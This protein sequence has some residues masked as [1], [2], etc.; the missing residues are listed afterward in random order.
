[1]RLASITLL[2]S[3]IAAAALSGCVRSEPAAHDPADAGAP[4]PDHAEQQATDTQPAQV[5]RTL[6]GERPSPPADGPSFSRYSGSGPVRVYRDENTDAVADPDTLIGKPVPAFS[7]NDI[8]GNT[9]TPESLKGS[10]VLLD[11]WASWCGPCLAT[12]PVMQALHE[13][14]A[15]RGLVVIGANVSEFDEGQLTHTPD[16]ARAYAAEHSYTYTFTY[17]S[18]DLKTACG[19]QGLPTFILIDRDGT[20]VEVITGSDDNL[21]ETLRHQI[22]ELLE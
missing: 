22:E 10:V 15:G 6:E 1:M 14:W 8:A 5:A 9:L 16:A 18:D 4:T 12:S 19:V 2:T 3:L 20:V 13:E 11:F 21:Q 17:G 7:L